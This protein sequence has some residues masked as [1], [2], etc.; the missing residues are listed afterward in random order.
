MAPSGSQSASSACNPLTWVKIGQSLGDV[1]ERPG[2]DS[3]RMRGPGTVCLSI[4]NTKAD[5]ME[6][7]QTRGAKDPHTEEKKK[8]KVRDPVELTEAVSRCKV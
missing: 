1:S 2:N 5:K 3:A 8:K 6:R 4:C 7:G